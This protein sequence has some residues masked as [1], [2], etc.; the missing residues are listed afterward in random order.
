MRLKII[1]DGLAGAMEKHSPAV[2]A[3]EDVFQSKNARSALILGH[4]RG[5]ALVAAANYGAQVFSYSPSAVKK[6]L[7]AHGRADKRQIGR[8]VSLLLALDQIPAEDAGDALGVAICHG[9]R[10]KSAALLGGHP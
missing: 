3:V 10:A 4:A 9:M 1:Y 6:S 2:V 5:V 8:M 7:A